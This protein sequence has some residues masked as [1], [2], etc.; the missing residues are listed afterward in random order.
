[1]IRCSHIMLKFHTALCYLNAVIVSFYFV[2]TVVFLEIPSKRLP[3]FLQVVVLLSLCLLPLYVVKNTEKVLN[4]GNYDFSK[5][6]YSRQ[7]Q[8]KLILLIA[9]MATTM[10]TAFSFGILRATMNGF[11]YSSPLFK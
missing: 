10:M 6:R 7:L 4:F 11:D 9:Y 8:K 3:Y 5:S 1:M 2:A